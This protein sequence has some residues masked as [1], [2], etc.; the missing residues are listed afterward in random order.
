MVKSLWSYG[1]GVDN[2]S[3]FVIFGA[4]YFFFISFVL[5]AN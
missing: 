1:N 3:K 2:V 5:Q 4:A